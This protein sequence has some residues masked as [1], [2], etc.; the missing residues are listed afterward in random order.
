VGR[1]IAQH[2]AASLLALAAVGAALLRAC[3]S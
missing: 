1:W 2:P 3:L